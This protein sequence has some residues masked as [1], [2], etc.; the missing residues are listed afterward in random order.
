MRIDPGSVVEV[1]IDLANEGHTMRDPVI[2]V[3]TKNPF[4]R[5]LRLC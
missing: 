2:E 4:S 5:N 3:G 1:Q